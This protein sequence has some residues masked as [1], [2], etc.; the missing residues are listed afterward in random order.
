MKIKEGIFP[1]K[2]KKGEVIRSKNNKDVLIIAV[3][4]DEKP[5]YDVQLGKHDEWA[6]SIY[7]GIKEELI[8]HHTQR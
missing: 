2:Y 7:T 5:S 8:T 3:H 1:T 4:Y 6:E